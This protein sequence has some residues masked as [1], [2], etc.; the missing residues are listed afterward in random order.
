[1]SNHKVVNH[2]RDK[3]TDLQYPN[4]PFTF[5]ATLANLINHPYSRYWGLGTGKSQVQ[6]NM[7]K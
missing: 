6:N 4:T 5:A 2:M 3:A 1:M 7:E